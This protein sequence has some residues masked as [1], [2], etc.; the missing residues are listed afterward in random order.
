MGRVLTP[1]FVNDL[2]CEVLKPISD[3]VKSSNSELILCFRN[4][5]INVYYKGHNLFKIEKKGEHKYKVTFNLGHARYINTKDYLRVELQ[6]IWKQIKV[7]QG[8]DNNAYF[9]ISE[10][11]TP[12]IDEIISKYKSYID[13]FFASAAAHRVKPLHDYFKGADAN[14]PKSLLEKERQ[15]EIF[16][17]YNKISKHESKGELVFYDMELSLPGKTSAGS[18]DCLAAKVEDGHVT[19]IVLVEVKSTESACEGKHGIAKHS[20]DYRAII[21]SDKEKENLYEAMKFALKAYDELGIYQNTANNI[22][23][24]DKCQFYILYL[25]TDGAIKWAENEKRNSQN[26]KRYKAIVADDCND[27]PERIEFLKI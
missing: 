27:S 24:L 10:A 11:L 25:F 20:C 23:K 18:P 19:G 5:Y 2:S 14:V 22:C 8:K 1:D 3:A 9:Y 7:P 6:T 15:Q 16:T 12:P 13:N 4:N 21:E 17:N 26:Y